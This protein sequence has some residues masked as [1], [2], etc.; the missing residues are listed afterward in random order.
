[1]K[2]SPWQKPELDPGT[3]VSLA[4]ATVQAR[5]CCFAHA[6]STALRGTSNIHKELNKN[7]CSDLKKEKS[8]SDARLQSCHCIFLRWKNRALYS[9]CSL[10]ALLYSKLIQRSVKKE[11]IFLLQDGLWFTIGNKSRSKLLRYEGKSGRRPPAD[12]DSLLG[13]APLCFKARFPSLKI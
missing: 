13:L 9:K 4:K 3:G 5:A 6:V 10:F 8:G 11:K 12:E 2:E 1:M 7:L